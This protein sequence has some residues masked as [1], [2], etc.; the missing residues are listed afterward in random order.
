MTTNVS[1]AG[2]VR[3]GPPKTAK[4]RR[5]IDLDP[6]T[7]AL[8]RRWRLAQDPSPYVAPMHPGRSATASTPL[9]RDWRRTADAPRIRF[10]DL[11]HRRDADAGGGIPVHVV[12]GR[13]GHAAPT[14]LSRCRARATD[15]GNRSGSDDGRGR[16]VRT[17]LR[18]QG[19]ERWATR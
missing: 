1:V 6:A 12:A 10:H 11:R 17:M 4:G 16:N 14:I 7:V 18:W 5:V 19:I 9:V 2:T 3:E 13:L 8:L 15:A